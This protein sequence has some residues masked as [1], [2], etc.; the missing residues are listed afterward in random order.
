MPVRH[1]LGYRGYVGPTVKTRKLI[2]GLGGWSGTFVGVTY[3]S[4]GLGFTEMGEECAEED[5][6]DFI[7]S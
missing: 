5:L 6:V 2:W 4:D 3:R 7:D 1:R